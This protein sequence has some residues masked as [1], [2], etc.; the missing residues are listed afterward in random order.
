MEHIVEFMV[1]GVCLLC[2]GGSVAKLL[3]VR[4]VDHRLAIAI[5]HDWVAEI[6]TYAI[7]A[8]YAVARYMDVLHTWHYGV[9]AA[10]TGVMCVINFIT[11]V[12]VWRELRR[13]KN[14]D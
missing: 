9:T 11:S 1:A 8:V 14:S 2:L 12:R 5:R 4:Q 10:L 13:I 3:S 7:G 6:G